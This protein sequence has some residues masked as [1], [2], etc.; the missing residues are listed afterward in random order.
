MRQEDVK[1]LR[2]VRLLGPE[3]WDISDND[4]YNKIKHRKRAVKLVILDQEIIAGAGNIY[5]N[6][7]LWEAGIKPTR[8]AKTLRQKD[9]ETL[10]LALVKVLREGIKYGGSTAK[11]SKYVQL[12]GGSGKYQEH[13]RVY[14]RKGLQC[15]RRDGGII[16]K[17]TLGGR[18]TYYCPICQ[19]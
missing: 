15:L 8:V 1:T 19:T 18:G 16:K 3:P 9:C 5:A 17:I 6:D 2:Y 10:R 13:F 4:L 7:A 11:D 12:D 14:D